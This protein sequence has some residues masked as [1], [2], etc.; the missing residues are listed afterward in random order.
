M[1]S[2]TPNPDL[3]QRESKKGQLE[4]YQ[5]TAAEDGDE[6]GSFTMDGSEEHLM[7]SIFAS[8]L[9]TSVSTPNLIKLHVFIQG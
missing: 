2:S 6:W 3:G 1:S 5:E 7:A 4:L 9:L 8:S